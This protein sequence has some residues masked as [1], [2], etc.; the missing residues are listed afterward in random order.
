MS[1][2]TLKRGATNARGYNGKAVQTSTK[3]KLFYNTP[4]GNKV[5]VEPSKT[6]ALK[7]KGKQVKESANGKFFY[8][9]SGG[10]KTYVT[11]VQIQS[12]TGTS[13]G[14]SSTRRTKR[15]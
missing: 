13:T 6:S 14:T 10:N 2:S 4:S 15:Q 9:T 12:V 5:Y 11:P 1:T 8:E 3:G 7:Y